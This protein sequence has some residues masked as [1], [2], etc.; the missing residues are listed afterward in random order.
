[1]LRIS[2]GRKTHC[3][4][5]LPSGDNLRI[6]RPLG[7]ISL[8]RAGTGKRL[9]S[10]PHPLK[11]LRV[12]V[13]CRQGNGRYSQCLCGR[14]SPKRV[15]GHVPAHHRAC[16]YDRTFT[17][18]H[19]RQ[20][21]TVWSNENVSFHDDFLGVFRP[22]GPPVKMGKYG[23]SKAKGAIIANRDILGV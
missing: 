3:P 19:V 6:S 14:A 21:D 22:L 4:L 8:A 17:N 5:D 7:Q 20:D 18:S 11:E 23:G 1:M 15:W 16:A 9:L 2:R 12:S 13:V 10:L